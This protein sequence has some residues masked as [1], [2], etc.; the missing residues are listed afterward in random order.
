MSRSA[1][2]LS[3]LLLAC[4]LP[5]G[6]QAATGAGGLCADAERD[7]LAF[8]AAPN[9]ADRILRM[10]TRCPEL[11]LA[12]TNTATNSVVATTGT[13]KKS[14]ERPTADFS[15]LIDRLHTATRNLGVATANVQKAQVALDRSIRRATRTGLSEA[16]LQALYAMEP[17][18]AETLLPDF[19]TAKRK[20]LESYVEARD[21]LA[22]AEEKLDQANEKAKPLVERALELAGKAD[23]AEAE[24][25]AALG[26]LTKDEK[27]ALLDKALNDAKASLAELEGR[28][29]AAEAAFDAATKA[30]NSAMDDKR[31]KRAAREV[32]EETKDYARAAKNLSEAEEKFAAAE[33]RF[34][35]Q[36]AKDDKCKGSDCRNAKLDAFRA[37][38]QLAAAKHEMEQQ[39]DDLEDAQKDL[40]K[41][42]K[43]LGLAKLNEDYTTQ[44]AALA[45]AQAAEAIARELADATSRQS[46]E[47][48]DLLSSAAKALAEAQAASDEAKAATAAEEAEVAAASLALEKALADAKAALAGSPEEWAAVEAVNDAKVELQ[49]ALAALGVAQEEADALAEEVAALPDVPAEVQDAADDMSDAADAAETAAAGT[50][51]SLHAA[52]EALNENWNAGGDLHDAL[53]ADGHTDTSAADTDGTSE[54]ESADG[55]QSA[56]AAGDA[57][58]ESDAGGQ[59]GQGDGADGGAD[60][61]EGQANS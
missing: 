43:A 3:A 14:K 46:Q 26:G 28:I 32:E 31:Y 11:A 1:A 47:L 48:A 41:I 4:L 38:G 5:V 27:Q 25:G 17:D 9:F 45:A 10:S 19:N 42:E 2:P 22:E 18:T 49:K 39:T 51:E 15:D 29:A 37:G 16:E 8:I 35:E 56:E 52:G 60:G 58:S 61:G 34:K 36:L 54:G 12:L 33:A 20:A 24:L 13:D 55:D 40:A 21:R 44:A 53:A 6:A 59:D 57:G 30:L 23:I 50:D 7:P